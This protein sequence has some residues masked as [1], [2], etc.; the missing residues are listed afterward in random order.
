MER[1]CFD[2]GGFRHIICHCRNRK[3]KELVSMFL[4]RFKVLKSSIIQRGE[5]SGKKEEKDKRTILKEEKL[6]EKLVEV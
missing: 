3:E 4:N 6:K 2:C 5:D 1:K